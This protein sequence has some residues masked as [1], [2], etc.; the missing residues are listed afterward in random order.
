M[1]ILLI[2][3]G[4]LLLFSLG[5]CN[6]KSGKIEFLKEHESEITD[7]IESKNPNIKKV[8]YDWNSLEI[9][10]SGAFTE[11]LYNIEFNY[12]PSKYPDYSVSMSI[13]VDNLN[14]PK[15]IKKISIPDLSE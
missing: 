2:F 8:T 9:G 15:K 3:T 10:D 14:N 5:G 11:K 13:Y 7:Y 1:K 4:L 12:E 6:M